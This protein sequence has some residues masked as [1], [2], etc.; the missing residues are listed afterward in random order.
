MKLYE[1]AKLVRSKNAGPFYLTIDIL[2][3]NL[4]IYEKVKQSGVLNAA[5]ISGIYGIPEQ[6]V[7]SFACDEAMAIKFSFPRP[8]VAGD[9]ADTDVFGGQQHGPLVDIEIP[10]N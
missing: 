9:F 8:V 5:F 10:I 1:L 3:A 7:Q 4:E 6:A 2:F